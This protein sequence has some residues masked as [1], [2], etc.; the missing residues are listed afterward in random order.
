MFVCHFYPSYIHLSLT[1]G[2]NNK[3]VFFWDYLVNTN[4]YTQLLNTQVIYFL[5]F[6][7]RFLSRQF[8]WGTPWYFAI[9]C[10]DS[11]G[12][13]KYPDKKNDDNDGGADARND[14]DYDIID[15]GK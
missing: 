11:N 12:D 2:E 6:L 3:K 7:Y 4:K 5:D 15:Q 13:K 1:R 10:N 9:G 14:D 8:N